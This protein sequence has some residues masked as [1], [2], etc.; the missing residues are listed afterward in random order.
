VLTRICYV[1]S[2]KDYKLA[3]TLL[4][5]QGGTKLTNKG[6]LRRSR[7]WL[8]CFSLENGSFY[9][10]FG[11]DPQKE[12]EAGPGMSLTKQALNRFKT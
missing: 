2:H 8:L 7:F 5:Y 1:W 10:T 4:N 3:L 9:K 11:M 6:L 12:P